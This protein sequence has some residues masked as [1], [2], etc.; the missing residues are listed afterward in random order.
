MSVKKKSKKEAGE[1]DIIIS[2][3]SPKKENNPL[4]IAEADK[5]FADRATLA[6][7]RDGKLVTPR[8]YGHS[9]QKVQELEEKAS[10]AGRAFV[11]PLD[12]KGAYWGCIE[13]LGELGIDQWHVHSSIFKKM[14][15]IME[16]QKN[17]KG[18]NIWDKFEGREER[19]GAQNP[20]SL[21]GRIQ[22]NARVLQRLGG[23]HTYGYKLKQFCMSVDIH[24]EPKDGEDGRNAEDFPQPGTW[25]YKLNTLWSEPDSVIPIYDN[26]APRKKRKPSNK[27]KIQES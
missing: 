5:P 27:V 12:R 6:V 1:G 19:P 7:G 21:Q 16:V 15:E 26:K 13:S 14:R 18:E 8:R 11:N 25:Y 10:E 24:I 23:Y 3:S 9:T 17:G 2:N 20:K 22:Q 4:Y